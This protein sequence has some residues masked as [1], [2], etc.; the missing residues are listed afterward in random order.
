M[1]LTVQTSN[2]PFPPENTY[3]HRFTVYLICV[4]SITK[5]TRFYVVIVIFFLRIMTDWLSKLKRA[6]KTCCVVNNLKKVHFD[7]GD[8]QEMIEE[9]NIDTKVVTR[10]AWRNKTHLDRGDHWHIEIGDPD[11]MYTLHDG[12]LIK[13]CPSQPIVSTRL[14]KTSLEWRIRNLEYPSNVYSVNINTEKGDIVVSTSNRKYYKRL[15]IPDLDR[16]NIRPQQDCISYSHKFNTLIILYKKPRELLEV[17]KQVLEI[18][19]KLKP[20][21]NEK[22]VGCAPS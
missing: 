22:D 13:E 7:F 10:R 16:L 20:N 9:Y 5:N 3:F 17:E 4:I 11:P 19:D 14:T 1:Q 6:K 2:K 21:S 18:V 12:K 15:G 8:G